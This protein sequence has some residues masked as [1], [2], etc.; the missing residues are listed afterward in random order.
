VQVLVFIL[1][2]VVERVGLPH[3]DSTQPEIQGH[4]VL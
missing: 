1:G 4:V 2:N 3:S